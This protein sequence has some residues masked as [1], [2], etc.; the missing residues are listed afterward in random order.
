[1]GTVADR[2]PT[3]P[4]VEEDVGEDRKRFGYHRPDDR[5]GLR[6]GNCDRC[7]WSGW[8][9]CRW[10]RRR[11]DRNGRWRRRIEALYRTER[12]AESRPGLERGDPPVPVEHDV[13][14]GMVVADLRC[15]REPGPHRELVAE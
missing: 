10:W 11:R 8:I 7:G 6:G 9:G 13:A 3:A 4:A 2:Q 14:E 1:E 15:N 12:P 5:K